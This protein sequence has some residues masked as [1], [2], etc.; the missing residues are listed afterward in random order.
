MACYRDSFTFFLSLWLLFF[1]TDSALIQ[2]HAEG[3]F[4]GILTEK[5]NVD[6]SKFVMSEF[7]GI[8]V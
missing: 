3:N 8:E 2:C 5:I 1:H 4:G 7:L 6:S